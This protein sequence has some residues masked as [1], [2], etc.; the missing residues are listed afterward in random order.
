MK[1]GVKAFITRILPSMDLSVPVFLV[2]VSTLEKMTVPSNDL[3]NIQPKQNASMKCESMIR[4]GTGGVG[5]VLDGSESLPVDLVD[6][7]ESHPL[8][9]QVTGICDIQHLVCLY[10]LNFGFY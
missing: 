9:G 1:R 5:E 2:P 4:N 10:V 6:T 7:Y 8:A 3:V